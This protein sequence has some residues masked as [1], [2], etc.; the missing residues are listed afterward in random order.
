MYLKRQSGHFFL[1]YLAFFVVLFLAVASFVSAA[2]NK[3]PA[4]KP[5]AAFSGS[6]S[7]GDIIKILIRDDSIAPISAQT[8]LT[9]GSCGFNKG[10]AEVGGMTGPMSYRV[11]DSSNSRNDDCEHAKFWAYKRRWTANKLIE[12]SAFFSIS[13]RGEETVSSPSFVVLPLRL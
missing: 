7:S 12:S 11:A 1:S 4:K 8:F 6:G 2:E 10:L 3:N 13:Q 9:G 5:A